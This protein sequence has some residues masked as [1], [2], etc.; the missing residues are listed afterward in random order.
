MVQRRVSLTLRHEKFQRLDWTVR[1]PLACLYVQTSECGLFGDLVTDHHS[2]IHLA[3]IVE[4]I[5]TIGL[6]HLCS[7]VEHI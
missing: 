6:T 7:I 3:I 5:L 1:S 2:V 4:L